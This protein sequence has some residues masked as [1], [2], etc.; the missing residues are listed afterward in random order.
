MVV[1]LQK[2]YTSVSQLQSSG[3]TC[4]NLDIEKHCS[5]LLYSVLFYIY[6]ITRQNL[7]PQPITNTMLAHCILIQNKIMHK[8]MQDFFPPDLNI[9]NLETCLY[10]A[11]YST[12]A[13]SQL[14]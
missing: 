14:F 5:K 2:L 7:I 9:L 12:S 13:I 10:Y 8:T 1:I 4:Q 6:I 11:I 3:R